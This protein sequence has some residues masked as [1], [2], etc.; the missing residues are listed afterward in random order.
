MVTKNLNVV[1]S[2]CMKLRANFVIAAVKVE[3]NQIKS[4]LLPFSTPVLERSTRRFISA[5][6]NTSSCSVERQWLQVRTSNFAV[7]Q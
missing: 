7:P 6:V 3:E 2:A 5:S 1:F 4:L